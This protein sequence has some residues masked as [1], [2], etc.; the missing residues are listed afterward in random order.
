MRGGEDDG[1]LGGRRVG[2]LPPLVVVVVA[3]QLIQDGGGGRLLPGGLETGAIGGTEDVAVG[4]GE[5]LEVA[6][7][8]GY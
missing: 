4:V 7:Q 2:V 8:V 1:D 6:L 3:V 5:C